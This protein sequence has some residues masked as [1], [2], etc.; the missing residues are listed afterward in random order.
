[1]SRERLDR[2]HSGAACAISNGLMSEDMLAAIFAPWFDVDVKISDERM[3][4]VSGVRKTG[5]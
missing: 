4:Q 2:H 1:M 3:Y 5:S